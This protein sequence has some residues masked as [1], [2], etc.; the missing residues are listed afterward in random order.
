MA[1]PLPYN[2]QNALASRIASENA[3]HIAG[4]IVLTTGVTQGGLGA[5]FVE[6]VAK[7]QP[8][9][10]ILAGRSPVKVQATADK[11]KANPESANVETR[12]LVMDLSSQQDVRR[13]AHEVLEYPE[14]RID[15]LVNS[16]GVMAG[17]YRTTEED[18]EMQFGS[19]HLGHFLFTNLIMSRLLACSSPRIV[20]VSSDGHRW[21]G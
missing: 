4:K 11:I 9:L 13:A 5:C 12:I 6:Q 21:S 7:Q 15:V 8:A 20:N 14:Q 19:N 2:R 10:V 18:I 1:L 16:A 3:E 17:P